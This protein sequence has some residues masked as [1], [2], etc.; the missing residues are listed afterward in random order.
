MLTPSAVAAAPMRTVSA[1]E[2]S[3]RA[4]Q[5][6]P[7]ATE[8]CERFQASTRRAEPD[9]VGEVAEGDVDEEAPVERDGAPAGPLGGVKEAHAA[10]PV[11]LGA[12]IERDDEGGLAGEVDVRILGGELLEADHVA[13]I[14]REGPVRGGGALAADD[15][16]ARALGLLQQRDLRLRCG[17][18]GRRLVGA[19]AAAGE[20]REREEERGAAL[21]AAH[22]SRD[23]TTGH[24]VGYA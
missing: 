3:V 21:H 5:P 1:A 9:R 18:R 17:R 16:L 14:E 4:W 23:L 2:I 19:P 6:Y 24:R 12:A 13:A 8:P 15:D 22:R 11:L 20:R 7:A 10:G